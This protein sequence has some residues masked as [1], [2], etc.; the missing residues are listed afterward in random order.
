MNTIKQSAELLQQG[1]WVAQGD[2]TV[3]P[4]DEIP[5]GLKVQK[6]ENGLMILAHSETGHHH[7]IDYSDQFDVYEN[8]EFTAYVHN[9][10]DNV[11]EL[12]HH[13]N[14]HTHAPIGIPPKSKVKIIRGREYTP[15]G[16]RRVAD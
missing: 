15:Q 9:R 5:D 8:D 4:I 12:K 1:E 13:R 16:L 6:S 7:A 2:L 14:F 10:S 3:C 11:I